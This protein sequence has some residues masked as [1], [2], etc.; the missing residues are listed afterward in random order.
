MSRLCLLPLLWGA[1]LAQ[2]SGEI[3]GRV[4]DAQTG[5]PIAHARLRVTDWSAGGQTNEIAVVTGDD[6]AF[7]LTNLPPGGYQLNFDRTGY[8]HAAQ[9]VQIQDAKP[10]SVTIAMTAQAV[11]EGTVVDENGRGVPLANIQAYRRTVAEGRRQAQLAGQTQAD[12]IGHFR[13]FGLTAGAYCLSVTVQSEV[14][15]SKMAHPPVFYPNAPS[16]ASAQFMDLRPGQE[17]QVPIRLPEPVPAVEISGQIV[18]ATESIGASLRPADSPVM[19]WNSY[20]MRW[21]PKTHSFKFTGVTPGVYVLDVNAQ[22][23]GQQKHATTTVAVAGHDIT[24]LRLELTNPLTLSGTMRV[25]GEAAPHP[26]TSLMLH[27]SSFQTA[28][29]VQPDGSFTFENLPPGTYRLAVNFQGAE[30]LRSAWQGSRD[31]LH[32]GLTISADTPPPPVEVVLGAPGGTVQGA[33]AS[34]DAAQS[35]AVLVALLRR[36]GDAMVLERQTYVVPSR[37]PRQFTLQGVPPGDYLLFAWPITAQVAYAEPEFI[38]Q[39]ES[40]GVPV[41]VSEGAKV[42]A[43]IEHVLVLNEP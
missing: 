7:D 3:A 33:G 42:T 22:I 6:G 29:Q 21:E 26:V 18:P 35:S 38:R 1:L 31:V 15:S 14:R 27:A 37:P 20:G 13:L 36:D 28:A 9:G 2:T 5:A 4:V 19:P 40:A 10:V 17:Q 16:L 43:N 11:I 25:E 24:G 30:Y 39:Y 8:L 12:D 41:N 32:D 34:S 23:D